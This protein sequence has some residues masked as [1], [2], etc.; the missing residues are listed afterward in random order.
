M[1][2]RGGALGAA[3][4]HCGCQNSLTLFKVTEDPTELL[5]R[6]IISFDFYTVEVKTE[7]ASKTQIHLH[8]NTKLTP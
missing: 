4:T 2:P 3:L 6:L 7:T 5:Y 1:Q 8:N